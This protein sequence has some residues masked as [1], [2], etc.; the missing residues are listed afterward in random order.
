MLRPISCT[1][2]VGVLFFISSSLA[3]SDF[4]WKDSYTRGAG[5]VPQGCAQNQDGIGAFC[6]DRCPEGYSR[7]GFDCHTNCPEGMRDDG[8]FC[9]RAEYGRGAGYPWHFGDALNDEGMFQRCR[10]ENP[11]GCE[12]N[13]LVVYPKCEE[14]YSAF[15][16]CIC[17][18]AQPD[19]PSLGLNRG[20]DLSCAK[21]IQIG[22]P[23]IGTCAEGYELD[24]GLCYPKCRNGYKGVGFVCWSRA[25]Q[26]WVECGMGA[27]ASSATCGTTV[28]S[29]V[30]SVG[31]LAFNIATAG[32]SSSVTQLQAPADPDKLAKLKAAWET[33]KNNEYVKKAVD[34]YETGKVVGKTYVTVNTALKATTTEDLVRLSAM[35]ASFTDPTG[36]A[37]VVSSYT[38]PKCS[39]LF[40]Q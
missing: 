39:K 16:C 33:I 8:L 21:R 26:N 30:T 28:F 5:V 35:I 15:G 34:A 27:A 38:Y 13:G 12:K 3:A 23:Q 24:A 20:I 2:A 19:C 40:G 14:G 37:G 36:V 29:Q 18:P 6:Y 32:A 25:P 4:C 31:Q 9:R 22:N 17:R 1:A 7:F 11:Q 10:A